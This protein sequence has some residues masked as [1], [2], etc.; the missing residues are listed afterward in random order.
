MTR[1]ALFMFH[2]VLLYLLLILHDNVKSHSANNVCA[3]LILIIVS[4]DDREGENEDNTWTI[5]MEH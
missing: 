4:M 3:F 1:Y 2:V 5:I